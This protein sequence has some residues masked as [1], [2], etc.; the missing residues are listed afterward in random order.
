MIG[1][2]IA[3]DIENARKSQRNLA[4]IDE[5]VS[6]ESSTMTELLHGARVGVE[7]FARRFLNP[8]DLRPDKEIIRAAR[9]W[10]EP[11]ERRLYGAGT[12]E[13]SLMRGSQFV[14]EL[15]KQ[16]ELLQKIATAPAVG[17]AG[18]GVGDLPSSIL[19]GA[20]GAP[21]GRL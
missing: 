1:Q 11:P 16:T 18:I 9:Q 15:K 4:K 19:S 7:H 17:G 14:D 21:M 5:F 3:Q 6:Q 20:I 8:L 2:G 12:D 13:A 10:T